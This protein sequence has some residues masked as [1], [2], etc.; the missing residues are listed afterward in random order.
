MDPY[1]EAVRKVIEIYVNKVGALE[2][3][4]QKVFVM[5]GLFTYLSTAEVK[6]LLNT[7]AFAKLRPVLLRK[8]DELSNDP[9]VRENVNHR[10]Q[11]V[12]RELFIYLVQ[13]DSI[14]RRQ[15]ERQKQL[16]VQHLNSCFE[17]CISPACMNIAAELKKWSAVDPATAA[18]PVSIK[19]LPRRSARLATIEE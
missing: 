3:K 8:I 17:Y 5:T 6:P 9:Y 16:T 14:A 18:K 10:T 4:E 15:S 11:V 13:D 2:K 12:L 7:R 19:V 1:V